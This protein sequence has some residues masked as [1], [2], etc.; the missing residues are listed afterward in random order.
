MTEAN[1]TIQGTLPGYTVVTSKVRLHCGL[2]S[3]FVANVLDRAETHCH[4]QFSR[5]VSLS[6]CD[7][8]WCHWQAV[9]EWLGATWAG[10]RNQNF[11]N[12]PSAL[13][14]ILQMATTSEW[15]DITW[16]VV[17]SVGAWC[18]SGCLWA[19]EWMFVLRDRHGAVCVSAPSSALPSRCGTVGMC[20]FA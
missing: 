3:Q 17:W 9:C 5:C 6:S 13:N 7:C 16:Q 19:H 4:R 1:S 20:S 18:A 14:T 8:V 15:V 2:P 11:D 10:A 12:V